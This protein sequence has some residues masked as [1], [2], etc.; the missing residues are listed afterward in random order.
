MYQSL[1]F[2]MLTIC[3]YKGHVSDNKVF[4]SED[5][6]AVPSDT[7]RV[8][9][10][11]EV[12]V[13]SQPKESF[14]LR[15]QPMSSSMFSASDMQNL[16]VRDLRE[17][18]V[19]VPSFSMPNYGSRYTSSMYVR[20]IGSRINSP[21]VGIYMDGMPIVSKSAFNV[22]SY[23][24][25]RV[26]ILRGPQGTLYGQ[27]TEG[28]LIRMYSRNPMTYQGTDINLSVG[29]AFY[30]NAEISHFNKV[31]DKFAFSVAGFYNGQNGFFKNQTTGERADKFNEA[32]GKVRLV[33][34]PTDRWNISYMADYQYV[35]Q[36]GFPYGLLD[37]NTG[38]TSDPSTNRQSNYRRNLFNTALDLNFR[39]NYF[40][41]NSTTS[42]QYLK[43][44]MM[45]D[46]DY[47]PEDFMH[48]EERQFQ[49]AFTQEFVLKGN[50]KSI[51]HW[52]LGAFGSF[53]WMKT[54]A[55]VHFNEGITNN[56]AKSVRDAMYNA[57]LN[58]MAGRMA[59]AGMPMEMALMQAAANIEKA[60]GISMDVSMEVPGL[61]HTPTFNV[62]FFHESSFDITDRLRATLG[63]RYDYT[64]VKLYY[65][66]YALMS[67][68][69]NVMGQT[70]TNN[71]TSYLNYKHHDNYDQFLPK[72]GLSYRIDDYGSNVYATWSKGYRAGG[73]NIQ[74]FSD[75]L[76]AELNANSQKANRS[77]YDIPH[78]ETDYDNMRNTI[79]YKPETSMNYE[80]GTHLNLFNNSMQLDVSAFY[81]KVQNQQLSV[82]A[83][84]YGYGRMMVNAGESYSCGVETTMRGKA[85]DNH[86]T[87]LLNYS[88]T[89]AVFKDY[90]DSIASANGGYELVNY[91][92]KK[93]PYVPEHSFSAA[94]DYRFD[95]SSTGLR[96][97][98]IG[99]NVNGLGKTYWDEENLY[100]QKLYLVLGAHADANFGPFTISVWGR[101]LTDSKYNTF[102]VSN[103]ATGK[104]AYYA[105]LGNP[106]QIGV[107]FRLHI[108]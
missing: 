79:A 13:V 101:N 26:D 43:D 18:S 30:R 14:R 12:I 78:T 87:W 1:I 83:G 50:R 91:K 8:Q 84:T 44:Y 16:D 54:W 65:D 36:N 67:L 99:A 51:W 11:D 70:A 10:L 98:V 2:L 34:T 103:S 40:D 80:F 90:Q 49:N 77:S 32:G 82:M 57:M 100:S 4:V 23:Q 39:G 75:I 38:E 46:I 27:N 19:Y 86:L 105:Q 47:V 28:G 94:A 29:T 104:K 61:F 7:S 74:M 66:T 15:Q 95:I 106:F 97:I 55:P 9:D 35:R 31:S 81:M 48:M 59:A 56:I 71:L 63:V 85:I 52:T 41:F 68:T 102:A 3:S 76:Q 37:L 17:L 92:D 33:F 22:H 88:Y 73:F 89:H 25:D 53:Q 24:L 60:G 62:G 96:S 107:D 20:G 93:V 108:K 72:V 45:M 6:E 58:S 64:H 21:A 69:A 42:Y 5:I